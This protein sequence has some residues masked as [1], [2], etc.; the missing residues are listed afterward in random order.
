MLECAWDIIYQQKNLVNQILT[1][2]K[3]V[4]ELS[5]RVSLQLKKLSFSDE[6]KQEV[7]GNVL[8]LFNALQNIVSDKKQL[9]TQSKQAFLDE[10]WGE[11][12][13]NF[14]FQYQ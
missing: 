10:A 4:T 5:K 3:E 14:I 11:L 13:A 8:E 2:K 1:G 7:I 6:V 12:E 9:P